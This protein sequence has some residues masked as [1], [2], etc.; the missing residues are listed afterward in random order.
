MHENQPQVYYFLDKTDPANP[1]LSPVEREHWRWVAVYSDGKKLYQ[2]DDRVQMF[3]QFQEINQE[4]LVEFRMVS[5]A[6]P[7]GHRMAFDPETMKLVHFYRNR[8]TQQVD[9]KG[10]PTGEE[11][12][13]RHYCY[14]FEKKLAGKVVKV[15]HQIAPDGS[16]T[17][18]IE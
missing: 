11:K 5:D 13:E 17:T 15:I 6:I 2:F 14:G 1:V 9:Y 16:I 8:R 4:K 7:D 3:H 18:S 10:E 12:R